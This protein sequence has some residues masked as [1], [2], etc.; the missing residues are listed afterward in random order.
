[1]VLREGGLCPLTSPLCAPL[2]FL[3]L[4]LGAAKVGRLEDARQTSFNQIHWS[5]V[6]TIS[7][8]TTGIEMH[9]CTF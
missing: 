6:C 1:M 2:G 9:D 4:L 3:K 5:I 7:T 8:R